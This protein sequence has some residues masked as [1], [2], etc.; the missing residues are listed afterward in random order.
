MYFHEKTSS[1][2]LIWDQT[3][4]MA[5]SWV[6]GAEDISKKNAHIFNCMFSIQP[7][8]WDI[9][10]TLVRGYFHGNDEGTVSAY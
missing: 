2:W 6:P 3:G 8:S 4:F 7:D 9:F 5:P 10:L 1:V